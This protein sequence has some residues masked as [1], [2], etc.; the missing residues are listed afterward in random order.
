MQTPQAKQEQEG[1]RRTPMFTGMVLFI[2]SEAFLFGSLFWSYYYLR[3]TTQVWPPAGANIERTLAITN[4][5][6]LPASSA[7]I[8]FA[9]TA[10]RKGNRRALITGLIATL[11]LGSAFL[12][13]TIWEWMHEPFTPWSHA[14]GS[15][16]FTLT[17]FHALHVFAGIL[18]MTALLI[19]SARGLYTSTNY[20]A[21]DTS[22]LYWHFVDFIWLFVFAS[23]FIVK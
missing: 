15:I 11:T 23:V 21:I 13:I 18:V 19:R 20:Q 1:T 22:S 5:I 3:A 10:I 14:Y 7:A 16:F 17:G 2:I 4:T 9:T 6:L 8:W 12:G